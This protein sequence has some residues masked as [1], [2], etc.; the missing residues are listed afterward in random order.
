[1]S[2]EEIRPFVGLSVQCKAVWM[3]HPVRGTLVRVVVDVLIIQCDC[4]V[5][6]V[7]AHHVTELSPYGSEKA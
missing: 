5:C 4:C 7:R 6:G 3:G 2:V 1:M